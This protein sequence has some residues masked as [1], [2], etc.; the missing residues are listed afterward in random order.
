ML[1][2]KHRL[3]SIAQLD[4]IR[5]TNWGAEIDI[6]SHYDQPGS[7]HITHDPW[8]RGENLEKWLEAY[9]AINPDGTLV[10]NTKEDVLESRCI[11]LLNKFGLKNYFFLDTALPTLVKWSV[12]LENPNFALRLSSFESAETVLKF[13]G[14][15][16]WVW[17]DCFDG[18]PMPRS[19]VDDLKSVFKICL[20]SPELQ[21]MPLES[22][23]QFMDLGNVADA[24]C[25]K[26]PTKWI[27]R[28]TSSAKR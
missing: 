22:I 8:T 15:V 7:L 5:G 21:G 4:Q 12:K 16:K 14:K 9:A 13:A 27:Q 18:K 28:Q 23:D 1:F 19:V 2:I 24:I 17:V 26:D 6:R 25:T 3:N 11:E 10:L 20:V